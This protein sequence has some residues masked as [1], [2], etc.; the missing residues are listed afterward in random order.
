MSLLSNIQLGQKFNKLTIIELTIIT[1]NSKTSIVKVKCDCGVEK[2]IKLENFRNTQ[3]CGCLY[4]ETRRTSKNKKHGYRNE[5]EYYIWRSMIQRCHNSK[6]KDFHRYGGRGIEVCPEW[7]QSF[8]K[9]ISYVGDRPSNKHQID[10]I[11]NT[12][13]Y[14][15][16][17]VRWVT[18]TTQM[19]NKT[20]NKIIEYQ[21][22]RKSVAQW[23]EDLNI[24]RHMIYNRLRAG[25]SPE[26]ALNPQYSPLYR[27]YKWNL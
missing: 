19:R 3:S 8:E 15:P 6:R 21:G 11:D 16:G 2:E 5:P 10:R 20:N 27:G 17:N 4:R 22:Q 13:G 14:E 24:S 26:E 25:K 12:K 7:Q 23:A 1:S 18:A 9:F